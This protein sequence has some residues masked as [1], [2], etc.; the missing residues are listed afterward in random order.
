MGLLMSHDIK[1]WVYIFY[2]ILF[3]FFL[4]KYKSHQTLPSLREEAKS[5]KV[6]DPKYTV[7]TARIAA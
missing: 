1:R 2:S 4:C 3:F 6:L 5:L 7:G